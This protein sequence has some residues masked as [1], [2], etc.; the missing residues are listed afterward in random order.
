MRLGLRQQGAGGR[1]DPDR[2][3]DD[4]LKGDDGLPFGRVTAYKPAPTGLGR[5]AG[6]GQRLDELAQVTLRLRFVII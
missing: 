6:R 2:A 4:D 5:H 3:G 1:L